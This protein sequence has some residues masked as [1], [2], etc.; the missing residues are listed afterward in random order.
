MSLAEALRWR[1]L[2]QIKEYRG[3]ND[4]LS[5]YNFHMHIGS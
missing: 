5:P 2:P 1:L 4:E 3:E